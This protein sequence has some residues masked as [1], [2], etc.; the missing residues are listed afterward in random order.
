MSYFT[1]R[2][3]KFLRDLK[4]HNARPWFES[5]RARYE[6]DVKE[7][8]LRFINDLGPGLRRISPHLVADPRPVGGSMFRIHRDIRFSRDKSPYKTG[9]GAH[10]QHA[11]AKHVH[12]P[13]FYL[14]IEPGR[15]SGGGGLWRP[16]AKPLKAVRD[17]I[18][19]RPGEWKSAR[20]RLDIEGETLKRVPAG[21]D[22]AHPFAEDLKL[23][24]FTTGTEFSDSE[25]CAQ[26]FMSRYLEVARAAAPLMQFLTKALQLPW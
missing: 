8:M 4:T 23:K 20:A 14:H 25:V 22:A 26:N 15:S 17:R 9:V 10:F 1:P 11:A 19:T 21:Y 16:D 18:A 7:P 6:A 3:F 2:F 5:N 13:G 12:A 24:D